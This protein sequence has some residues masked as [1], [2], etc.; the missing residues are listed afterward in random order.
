MIYVIAA[1]VLAFLLVAL[2]PA[3]KVRRYAV[4][5]EKITGSIRVALLTDLHSCRYG[6]NMRQLIQA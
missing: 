4:S 1:A 3:L 5:S 2:N 6:K